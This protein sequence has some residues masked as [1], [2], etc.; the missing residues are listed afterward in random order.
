MKIRHYKT[1]LINK[2]PALGA[3]CFFFKNRLLLEDFRYQEM[4]N[5]SYLK[6]FPF[7]KM[8]GKNGPSVN[9]TKCVVGWFDSAG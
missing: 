9:A 3:N 4:Q 5:G 6:L 2:V 1:A 8:V 7:A